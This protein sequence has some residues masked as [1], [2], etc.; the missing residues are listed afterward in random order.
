MIDCRIG[1]RVVRGP[2]WKFGNEDGGEGGLGT[3]IEVHEGDGAVNHPPAAAA[4]S[5]A[6]STV[7]ETVVVQWDTG[8]Q[9]TH[10]LGELRIFDT[11]TA[12]EED[13]M[14]KKKR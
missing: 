7:N 2:D 5:E 12:G 4:A 8:Q 14:M 10:G 3:V 6:A 1:T 13:G 9:A 11:T